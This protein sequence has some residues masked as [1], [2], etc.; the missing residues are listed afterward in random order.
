MISNIKYALMSGVTYRF[1]RG[2]INRFPAPSG[3]SEVLYRDLR[4]SGFEAAT[5]QRGTEIVISY[6]GTNPN[7]FPG[8]DWAANIGLATGTGSAQLLQAAQYYLEARQQN[9]T[10]TITLTGHSLGGGL[11]ALVGVFFGVEAQTFG[12]TPFANSARLDATSPDADV[13][14]N[15]RRDL[16]ALLDGNGNRLYDDALLAPLTSYLSL[17]TPENPIPRASLVDSI[18]VEGEFLEQ[19]FLGYS[20]IGN[21][22]VLLTHGPLSGLAAGPYLHS[23]SLHAAFLQSDQSAP[24]VASTHQTLSEVSKKLTDLLGMM[25]DA[26]LFARATDS[27]EANFLERIV[28]HE[29]G[30]GTTLPA[31]AMVTRFTADLWK[32]AQDGGLTMSDGN[33]SNATLKELSKALI[34]FAMQKYYEEQLA[35]GATPSELFTD[36]G[37]GSNGIRFDMRDVANLAATALDADKKIDFT[38]KDAKGNYL[39]K[40]YGSFVDYLKQRSLF[41]EAEAQIIDQL[42]PFLRDWYVQAGAAGMNA[43]DT[44]NRNA[45]MLGGT[46]ADTLTGGTGNDLL[47]GNLGADSLNGGA[48]TDNLLGGAGDD[49]LNGGAGSDLLYGGSG[50]DTYEFSGTFGLDVVIDSDGTGMLQ[51][52][53]AAAPTGGKLIA[54]EVWESDDK[55]YRYTQLDGKLIVSLNTPTSGGLNGAILVNA[56]QGGQF[57]VNLSGTATP[58]APTNTMDG[59]FV[60]KTN[61][62]ETHYLLGPDGNY[63]NDGVDPGKH[64]LIT[65]TAG[66]DLIRGLGGNDALLGRGGDDVIEGGD[67]VDILQGGLGRDTLNGGTGNDL[68]YGSS[69]GSLYYPTTVDYVPPPASFPVVIGQGFSWVRDSPG[70][71]AD[72]FEQGYL[73]ANVD[74]D[75][76][77][78]DDG[79]LIDGGIGDDVIFA[80]TGSDVVH[81]G[82]N[83]DDVLGMAG[84]DLLFGDAGRDRIYGDGPSVMTPASVIFTPPEQHGYDVISGG[85]G[86]DLLLGQGK[87]D[88]LFGG[89]DN[90]VLYGDDRDDVNTPVAVHGNDYLDGGSG[91]DKLY[92]NGG[93]DILIG[94]TGNDTIF[95]G[96]GKDTYIYNRGDGKDTILDT[97]SGNSTLRF[98][99]GIGAADPTLRLGSLML[100]LGNGDEVHINGIVAQDAN[101]TTYGFDHDDVF[102]SIAI[103]SFEFADGTLLTGSQLLERGFDI[104][105]TALDDVLSGTNTTDRINGLAGNDLLQGRGGNDALYGGVGNDELQGDADSVDVAAPFHGADLLDGGDG[106]DRLFGG[107]GADTLIGGAD[108]DHLD[109]D[110]DVAAVAAAFHG[111]DSL[112]GGNGNDSLIGGGGNDNLVG[113]GGDDLMTGD[114]VGVAANLHGADTLDGGT[115]NDFVLGEG[116]NDTLYGGDGNDWLAGEDQVEFRGASALTGDDV[117]DGGAGNDTLIGGNGND[118]LEGGSGIDDLFGGAG[119]DSLT[120]GAELDYLY[121]GEGSDRLDGGAGNDF[122]SGEEGSDTYVFGLGSGNDTIEGYGNQPSDSDAI[123]FLTGVS[124]ANVSILT[125][126]TIRCMAARRANLSSDRAGTISSAPGTG[127]TPWTAALETTV[128][129]EA[130]VRTRIASVAATVKTRCVKRRT[131]CRMSTP[132]CSRQTSKLPMSRSRAAG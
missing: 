118:Q 83:D 119:V 125:S 55:N 6:G 33:P 30:S 76:Q 13:A 75:E 11:A 49:T 84:N 62:E 99:A 24:L 25:F 103:G 47:V 54:P 113:G 17:R 105:G 59:D 77:P 22:P 94:G 38:A 121:G 70:R 95:G 48:G 9:P 41:T 131:R 109:G 69:N 53:G 67:G 74:R 96:E 98:G 45:F 44:L 28:Q 71:D 102:N 107:G 50:A 129:L 23:L 58:P 127:M 78:D 34:A 132:S 27:T 56:W 43:T 123:E 10:T 104:D 120:G 32:L 63:I 128:W 60:K 87:D 16:A 93:N 92:G 89:A 126:T 14:T 51:T 57:G 88:I 81:G 4:D 35:A 36:L 12:Q 79:N 15:L 73:D 114:R 39:I 82:D 20:P 130:M 101:S 122:V 106:A 66:G 61:V 1:A 29:A 64:D 40:G 117:L 90:D 116:G 37:Q 115:G 5:F 108:A 42:L 85:A 97:G 110:G 2:E 80:G 68:I 8:P 21:P 7:E 65:G 91:A 3:W 18:R 19:G 112:D 46:Q 100:D 26:K 111:D 124:P 52:V 72:G 86:D 31:D